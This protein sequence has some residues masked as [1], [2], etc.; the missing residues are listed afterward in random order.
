M[1]NG[2]FLGAL[3]ATLMV[4]GTALAERNETDQKASRGRAIKEQVLEKQKE[5]FSKSRVVS[6]RSDAK[7]S[8]IRNKREKGEVYGDQATRSNAASRSSSGGKNLSATNSVNN[9]SEIKAMLKMINPMNGAYRTSEAAEATDSY[10][11]G[12]AG[13]PSGAFRSQ[14]GKQKNLSA[15]GAVNNPSEIKAMKKIV[16]PMTGAYSTCAAAEGADSYTSD[17]SST[18]GNLMS[19]GDRAVRNVHFK[20]D[21]G[22]VLNSQKVDTSTAKKSREVREKLSKSFADKMSK[23]SD[24]GTDTAKKSIESK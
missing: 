16:N 11:G 14:G 7:Q 1:R 2:L 13:S 17:I 5:G 24:A 20:N 4:G 8:P 23:K 12:G 9:P 18:Y 19:H 22:E 21:K 10:G 6:S 3:L 15:T